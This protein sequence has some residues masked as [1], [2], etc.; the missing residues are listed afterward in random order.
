[1]LFIYFLWKAAE[2]I[3]QWVMV[4]VLRRVGDSLYLHKAEKSQLYA[5]EPFQCDGP[6]S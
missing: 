6:G 5:D 2:A 4:G 1:M 3:A